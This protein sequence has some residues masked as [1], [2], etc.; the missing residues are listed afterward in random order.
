MKAVLFAAAALVLAS[1]SESTGPAGNVR[2]E[3]T[4]SVYPLPGNPGPG[5]TISFS[6]RNRGSETVAL[7]QCGEGV[8]PELQRFEGG[9]WVT[10]ASGMC[11]ALA[12]YVPLLLAPGETAYGTVGT[13]VA[14]QYRLRV[15]VAAETGADFSS[16]AISP[17]FAVRWLED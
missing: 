5:A 13:T 4:Q 14:G 3:T 16:L 15:S 2:V 1:C 9:A 10:V 12:L 11:T 6:V 8:V 17:A 7:P